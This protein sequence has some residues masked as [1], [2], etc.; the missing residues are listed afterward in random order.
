[1]PYLTGAACII[2]EACPEILFPISGQ[3]CICDF[4][5][6][7]V[8]EL[9][10]VPCSEE[11][12]EENVTNPAWYSGLMD[13]DRLGRSGIGLGSIAKVSDKK[14]KAGSCRQEQIIF[15]V[16]GLKYQIKCFDK[17]AARKT[18]KQMNALISNFNR[19]L[20]IARMCDGDDVIIPIGTFTT[21]DFNWTVPENS[22]DNQVAELNLTWKEKGMPESV[23]VPGLSAVL[24]KL[25]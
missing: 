18:V 12:T 24:P 15:I 13:N 7:G 21:N 17:T 3:E 22:E 16:W 9:Y 8:N 2:S 23:D 11:F 6:G 5:G 19:F 20:L 1:M 14:D 25:V 4:A 10:F